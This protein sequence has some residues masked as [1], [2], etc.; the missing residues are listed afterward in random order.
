MLRVHAVI[1][2]C[3]DLE[4]YHLAYHFPSLKELAVSNRNFLLAFTAF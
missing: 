3:C 2:G 1:E 4:M